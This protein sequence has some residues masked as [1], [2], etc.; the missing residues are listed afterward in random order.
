ML[1]LARRDLGM[2]VICEGV[3]TGAERDT[4]AALGADLLQ[5]SLA[6]PAREFVVP[7]Y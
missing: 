4:L 1:D 5:G 2:I 7:S 6:R 3:E